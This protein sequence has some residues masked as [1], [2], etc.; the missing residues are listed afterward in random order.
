[1][2]VPHAQLPR[3]KIDQRDVAAV[4]VDDDEL[5]DAGARTL[6]P[7]SMKARER[8][9]A[10]RAS[11]CR[12][13]PCARP[14][15][16]PPARA[17]TPPANPS[18]AAR[19]RAPDTLPRCRYR[20]RPADAARAARPPRPAAP[21]CGPRRIPRSSGKASR[22]H[23]RLR[24]RGTVS[25]NIDQCLPV[26]RFRGRRRA[27]MVRANFNPSE[28]RMTLALARR[29][30]FAAFALL[31][32][33]RRTPSSSTR[34]RSAPTGSPRPSMAASIRRSPTAPTRNTAS[35]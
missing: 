35:T 22:S 31:R 34:S 7:I 3:R 32:R 6:S 16:R 33:A 23:R 14:R 30:L 11:A 4:A 12:E 24:A 9:F 18:A 27:T 13:T 20:R 10:A 8:G 19:A 25:T 28:P 17:E 5:A 15:R 29:A 2:F 26:T 21:R 1:M